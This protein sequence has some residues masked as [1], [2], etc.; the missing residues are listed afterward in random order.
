[1]DIPKRSII[2]VTRITDIARPA[3]QHRHYKREHGVPGI[4]ACGGPTMSVHSVSMATIENFLA[5]KRI[6]LVGISRHPRS[7]SAM[8]FKELSSRGYDMIPV[9]P[10]TREILGRHCFAR[11]QDI[12]PKLEA[13][14][15]MTTPEIT[16]V[17]VADCV[18]AGIR[19]VWMYRGIGKGAVS[20]RAVEFCR[21]HGIEV[22]PGECPFMFL[23]GTAGVHRIHGFLRKITGKYPTHAR[24][25]SNCAA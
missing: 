25:S 5:Q 21:E 9:N 10:S 24:T 7:D 16:D 11:V 15:L 6:A 2:H 20:T 19:Q 23:P 3:M 1:L 4:A 13:A 12:H 14:L 22:I 18:E 8:L 17:I